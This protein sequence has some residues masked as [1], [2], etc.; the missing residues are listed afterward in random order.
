M[1]R[2]F[3]DFSTASAIMRLPPKEGWQNH[4]TVADANTDFVHMLERA[5][6]T[7]P[8]TAKPAARKDDNKKEDGTLCQWDSALRKDLWL[9][10]MGDLL[11][12]HPS[13]LRQ[14]KPDNDKL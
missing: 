2:A 10:H 13:R 8:A 11:E 12:G 3:Q 4:W 7:D 9:E 6:H 14:E 1:G 5:N